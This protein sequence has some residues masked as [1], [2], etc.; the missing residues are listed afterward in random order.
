MSSCFEGLFSVRSMVIARWLLNCELPGMAQA[1]S[2]NHEL[3]GFQAIGRAELERGIRQR[4]GIAVEQRPD[5][6]D[7]IQ[8]ASE[9]DLA[10]CNIDRESKQ[11]RNARATL[12]RIREGTFGVCKRCEADIHSEPA[13]CDPVG[14]ALYCIVCREVVDRDCE[15]MRIPAHNLRSKAA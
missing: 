11:R 13:C 1:S 14:I 3:K 7:E 2:A 10:I 6:I 8:R 15:E 12:R 5:H 9:L 4:E